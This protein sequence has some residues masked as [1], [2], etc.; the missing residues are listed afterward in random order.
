MLKKIVY[1]L[2][3][4]SELEKE[5]LLKIINKENISDNDRT[6]L[7]VKLK[8]F[9]PISQNKY[10]I[11][12]LVNMINVKI[13]VGKSEDSLKIR[14]RGH[15]SKPINDHIKHSMNKYGK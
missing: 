7:I 2:D 11:Y 1:K 14:F 13:Y 9:G 8:K 3:Y 10:K 5:L 12:L 15:L 4:L 6:A